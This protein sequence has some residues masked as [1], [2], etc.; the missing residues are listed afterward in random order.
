[1]NKALD[2]SLFCIR[3]LG[4]GKVGENSVDRGQ[5]VGL[6]EVW[7]T[8][9]GKPHIPGNAVDLLDNAD[10]TQYKVIRNSPQNY[11]QPGDIVCWDGTWGGGFGHTA[12]VASANAMWLAVLE[13]NDPIG[14]SCRVATHGY[15]G[16]AGWITW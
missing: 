4:T 8:H 2:L 14:A 3:Y 7:L 13:Q 15:A 11:P 1:M 16:V 5:C 12:I 10:P 9:M 6:V